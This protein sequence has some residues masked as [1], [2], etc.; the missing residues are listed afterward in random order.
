MNTTLRLQ[1]EGLALA[2]PTKEICGFCVLAP[3]GL[4]II[5]CNNIAQKPEEDYEI[6]SPSLLGAQAM[7]RILWV[8]HSHPKAGGF[9]ENDL[10]YANESLFPQRLFSVSD[11][12]W[13]EYIPPGYSW[14]LTGRQWA[15][16]EAD[17]W[18][19]VRD[20]FRQGWGVKLNDYDRDEN[21]TGLGIEVLSNFE[22]EG[23][24]RLPGISQFM[25]HDVIVFRT[26]GSPQHM[27]IFQG[28]SQVLHHPLNGL[29]NL[30]QY[31][32][33]WQ[34]RVEFVARHRCVG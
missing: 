17:C 34:K 9:S 2:S 10:D 28:N 3:D 19:L 18:A 1:I 25:K 22:R 5:P 13:H 31:N 30:A 24:R 12:Q 14:P 21:S 32:T 26:H 20:Y 6:D 27:G 8:Y 11:R 29:S 4:H 23:F 15:W 16:G 7:G 33:A